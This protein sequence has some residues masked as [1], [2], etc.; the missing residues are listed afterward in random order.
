MVNR[1]PNDGGIVD[2]RHDDRRQRS[3]I[4]THIGERGESADSRHVEIQEQQVRFRIRLHNLVERCKALGFEY[5]GVWNA[6]VYRVYQRLSKEWVIIRNDESNAVR[7]WHCRSVSSIAVLAVL[8]E[9]LNNAWISKC[10]DIAEVVEVV[11]GD[12]P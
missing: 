5:L 9:L 2:C 10:R 6:V 11:F 1:T 12:F 3:V 8:D 7:L 4:V